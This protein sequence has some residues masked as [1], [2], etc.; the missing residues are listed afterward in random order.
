[1]REK[2]RE[3]SCEGERRSFLECKDESIF[4]DYSLYRSVSTVEVVI[5]LGSLA[6]RRPLFGP[7]VK[8]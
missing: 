7:L 1:M 5:W 3:T 4:I 2:V 8:S 6:R